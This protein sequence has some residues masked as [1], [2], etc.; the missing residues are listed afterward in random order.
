MGVPRLVF[1]YNGTAVRDREE[2]EKETNSLHTVRASG[3]VEFLEIIVDSYNHDI[4][5]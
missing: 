2:L 1:H 5:R 4:P 3:T